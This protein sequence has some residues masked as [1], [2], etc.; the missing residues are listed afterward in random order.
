MRKL[1]IAM[2]LASTALATPAVARDNS[3]YVGVEGGLMLVE[4]G[5][6]DATALIGNRVAV[7]AVVI[8][9]KTGRRFD[10]IGGYDFGVFRAE[11][12]AGYKRAS[13]DEIDSGR[14][15]IVDVDGSVRVFSVD[16][17]RAA[18]LRRRRRLERL[19]RRRRRPRQRALQDRPRQRRLRQR[20]RQRPRR[21]PIRALPA[22]AR[23]SATTSISASSIATSW[24]RSSN[25]DIE[26]GDADGQLQVA[27]AAREP[28][29]QLRRAAR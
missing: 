13:L 21:S 16:G 17:Q 20:Q 12:E 22:F 10:L 6:F 9:H 4:D 8:D 3:W 27:L 7:D 15:R 25:Y 18:R 2:A 5:D 14:R 19:C 11:V 24:R 29:L 23:R 26:F 1:A 28:D